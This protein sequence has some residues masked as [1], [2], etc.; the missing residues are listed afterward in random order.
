MVDVAV[1]TCV[2]STGSEVPQVLF[3]T[4]G[5]ARTRVVVV[6]A[7]PDPVVPTHRHARPGTRNKILPVITFG[8]QSNIFVWSYK[9]IVHFGKTF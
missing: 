2:R 7:G 1:R 4:E 6:R 8:K 3:D 5:R 9:N